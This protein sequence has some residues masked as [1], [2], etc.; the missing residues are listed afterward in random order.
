MYKEMFYVS[1]NHKQIYITA[2]YVCYLKGSWSTLPTSCICLHA[3][4]SLSLTPLR[5][6][7]WGLGWSW[8]SIWSGGGLSWFLRMQSISG[9]GYPLARKT[10][11]TSIQ[12]KYFLSRFSYLYRFRN[13]FGSK[14]PELD[15]NSGRCD[16]AQ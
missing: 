6:R 9:V 2:I 12:V 4:S 10:T 14:H 3:R 5:C 13:I 16:Y 8:V 7:K 11:T 1:Q 15:V